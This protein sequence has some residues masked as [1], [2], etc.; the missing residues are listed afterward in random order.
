[1][2]TMSTPEKDQKSS[3]KSRDYLN[4]TTTRSINQIEGEL[5]QFEER[6]TRM[7]ERMEEWIQLRAGDI[8]NIHDNVDGQGGESESE[9]LPHRWTT[10]PGTWKPKP[11]GVL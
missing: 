3:K 8:T 1:M 2:F 6:L 9:G 10:Y 5:S 11:L 4:A 7:D